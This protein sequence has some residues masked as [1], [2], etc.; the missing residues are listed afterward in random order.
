MNVVDAGG[1]VRLDLTHWL[2]HGLLDPAEL[3]GR[4]FT[5]ILIFQLPED[6]SAGDYG[7]EVAVYEPGP[8]DRTVLDLGLGTFG[9]HRFP[10]RIG[11]NPPGV[12]PGSVRAASFR[13]QAPAPPPAG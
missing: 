9:Q 4:R 11:A 10:V 8:G 7:L 2:V 6:W 12:T 5:E 13:L 3:G 1:R